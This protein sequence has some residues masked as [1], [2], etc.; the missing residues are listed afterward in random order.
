MYSHPFYVPP[1]P[2][3]LLGLLSPSL[4]ERTRRESPLATLSPMGRTPYP[5]QGPVW[6]A[7]H[8][9]LA[10]PGNRYRYGLLLPPGERPPRERE[11]LRAFPLPEGGWLV[12]SRE[13]R[14]GNLEL[15]DLAQ[16]PLRVGPFLLTW[17]GMRRDKTQRARFLV[18]P[19]WV[20]ERQREMERLVG[21][22]RWP[23]DRKRVKPLVLA[24]ARRLVGRTNALT[25]EVREAAKVGFLPPATANR[26]DK[27]VRRS[28]RKALTGLG[29]TKGEISE[30]LGRV[31]RL[32]QRRGE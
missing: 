27:A 8:R 17:G 28:L 25:R 2:S 29:L 14:V 5:W 22:F 9:A 21:S 7:L 4:R 31:V 20:R 15:Q 24:E 3:P 11:G 26:W 30:L 6:K 32:K 23:H 16:R 12:L 10:H 18:S 13:A 1:L 19:A